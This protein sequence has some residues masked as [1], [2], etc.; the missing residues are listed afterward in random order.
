VTL[1]SVWTPQVWVLPA[2]TDSKES[3]GGLLWPSSLAPQQVTLPSVW[4]PQVWKSPA[5]M[6]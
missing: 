1:P 6:D 5:E 4:T 3:A 2:E